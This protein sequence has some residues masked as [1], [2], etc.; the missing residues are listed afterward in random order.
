MLFNKTII[1]DHVRSQTF[2]LYNYF[3]FAFLLQISSMQSGAFYTGSLNVPGQGF[4]VFGGS[5]KNLSTMQQ[6]RSL[7]GQWELG[8]SLFEKKSNTAHCVVQVN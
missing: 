2:V 7:D 5:S 3:I 8:P 1:R 4:I 6:L